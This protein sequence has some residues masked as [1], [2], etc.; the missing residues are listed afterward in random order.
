M[1]QRRGRKWL[2]WLGT[3]L[4]LVALFLALFRWDW[5]IPFI[6]PRASAA[7]GRPVTLEHLHV[8]LG[9]TII[10]SAEG[11]TVGNPEDFPDPT[12]LARI[13]K[14][15][16]AINAWDWWRGQPLTLPWIE[17]EQPVL[18]VASTPDGK[19]N[20][21]LNTGNTAPDPAGAEP[22]PAP[23]IG[24]VRIRDGQGQVT[25]P[26]LRADFALRMETQEPE[27]QEARIVVSAEGQY[28][29]QPIKA[30]LI[31]GA[32]LSLRDTEKPWPLELQVDN[33]PTRVTLEGT[34]QDPLHF[35]GASL[36]LV[37]T[38]P[39]MSLLTPLTG[40]PIPR[41]PK[42]RVAGALDY[43]EGRIRFERIEGTVGR[44]DVAGA[45]TILP[46]DPRPDITVNLTSNRVDLD[47]LA[48]FIGETPGESGPSRANDRVLPN[49]PVSIP[50][51]TA[52]DMHVNYRARQIR[53]GRSMPLDDLRAEFDIVD[54]VIN[55]HP[56]GFGVGRGNM[57]FEGTLAPVDE[58]GLR[59]DVKARFQRLDISR[60]MNAAGSQGGGTLSGRA[61]LRSTGASLA[62]LLGRGDGRVT[63]TTSGGNLSALLVDLSGLRL[64]NAIL[65]AL[66]LPQRTTLQCFIADLELRRGTLQTK[67]MIIDTDDAI[68][69]G[70]GSIDLARERLAYRLRTQS[71]DFTIGALSTDIR[72][73]GTFREPGVM[74]EPLELGAR[75][76]A[77]VGLAFINPLL[78]ILP[79]I[80]FGTDEDSGC[81][82]LARRAPGAGQR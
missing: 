9:R 6:E 20:Y 59:A 44:S 42:Y 65:S 31:G 63:L 69:V 7:I 76:G 32:L 53:G 51:L 50:K 48:G 1:V 41:T 35:R 80:Q 46:R 24:M 23:Q 57:L 72:I 64:A 43:G 11:V 19:A 74:P 73:R 29:E 5:L 67:A 15:S 79:T 34:V 21:L 4:L 14:L 55:L 40:V 33:G 22:A 39:D 12:P 27:G 71:R 38:G 25:L 62:Q 70:D 68:I 36:Q 2:L 61:E 3:P 30:N 54:G 58:G 49:T 75:G 78:A 10:V 8:S 37:L 82:A 56:I 17:V 77:A 18:H 26:Q 81:Q 45:V 60:L 47:D 28:A 13:A 16:A 66:G 52:A